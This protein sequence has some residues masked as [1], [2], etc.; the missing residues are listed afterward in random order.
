MIEVAYPRPALGAVG[1][2]EVRRLV[3]RERE[4]HLSSSGIEVSGNVG[5]TPSIVNEE[6]QL[7]HFQ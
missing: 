6:S 3:C 2:V 5:V 7:S 1:V 4:G